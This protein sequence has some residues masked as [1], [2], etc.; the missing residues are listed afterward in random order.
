MSEGDVLAGKYRVDKVL[1]V[2]GM[3]VVVA[4]HHIQ[5]DER[6]AL[7]FLLPEALHNAEAVARF[8]REA[9]AAVKI[10][11]EHVVRVS[12]V[13]RLDGGSPYMVME[14]LD[15]SDLSEML[16]R[17]GPLPVAQAVEF[18]LQAS[19]AIAEAHA[20]GIVHRD[21]K[22]ANLYCIRRADG[23]PCVKVLD[24]GISKVSAP[25]AQDVAMTRTSAIVGSP[26]YM[27][28]EQMQS[29]KGVDPRTD[30]WSLGVI[31]FELLSGRLPFE[32]ESVTELAIKIAMEPPLFLPQVRQG[33]PDGLWPVVARCLEKDRAKR[34]QNVGELASG[35][36]PF[37]PSA[38][39]S[40]DRVLRT[41]RQS[42]PPAALAPTVTDAAGAG[43][44]TNAAW[45]RT[46]SA[47][48]P[49]PSRRGSVAVIASAIGIAAALIAGT[50]LVTRRPAA[51][52]STATPPLPATTVAPTASAP[53]PSSAAPVAIPD[54]PAAAAI[55]S[56]SPAPTPRS[57]PI[58]AAAPI[59]RP[60]PAPIAP[61]PA[62]APAPAPAA[63]N[64]N[65]PYVIDSA[66]HRQYKPECL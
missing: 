31:L 10:K 9:R 4:A 36:A 17:T 60:T 30:V 15:G 27:S 57:S 44:A 21:L 18:V 5:L 12:D 2:G 11:S 56:L 66:G 23:S 38:R 34:F 47:D 20:L 61:T 35:L 41:L 28:P 19:E 22:P 58:P 13:G 29:S 14:Y 6:V 3:G 40:V 26:L 54:A 53:S 48:A 45:G 46:G 49:R 1:G 59:A 62:P 55:P 25:G 8:E 42:A 33:V 65:P 63:K 7:K 52:A 37:A 39:S 16:R 50:I 32:A 43:V 64:C 51:P 24:F